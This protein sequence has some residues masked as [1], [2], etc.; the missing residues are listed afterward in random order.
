MKTQEEIVARVNSIRGTGSDFLGFRSEVLLEAL[1]F[2]HVQPYLKKGVTAEKWGEHLDEPRLREEAAKYL[3]FAWTK[4][5]GHRGISASR[6]I[7]KLGEY[8]WL[9]DR[10]DISEEVRNAPHENYGV[11]GL[12]I[13]AKAFELPVP[14]DPRLARMGAGEACQHE[15]LDGCGRG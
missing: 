15:C 11:P 5:R 3:D 12:M 14:D 4:A 6:S 8:A 2:D 1:D 9:L 10:D 13:F 7:E